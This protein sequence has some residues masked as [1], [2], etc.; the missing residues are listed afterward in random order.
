VILQT[1]WEKNK[2]DLNTMF[3]DVYWGEELTK[4]IRTANF[5]RSNRATFLTS[6]MGLSFLLLMPRTEDDVMVMGS[7]WQRRLRAGK[8]VTTADY[9]AAEK[10]PRMP[11]LRWDEVCMLFTTWALLL[12]MLFGPRC[13]HLVGLNSIRQ[14]VMSLSSTKHMYDATYF[15]NM[16]WC[17]LDDAVR[18]L[19][20]VVPYDDLVSA[21]EVECLQFPTT[22]LHRVADML[23]MQ[24]N[25]TMATFPREWRVYAEKR[26]TFG[27]FPATVSFGSS[28]TPTGS[29]T[30]GVSTITNSNKTPNSTLG[31]EEK[32]KEAP[33]DNNKQHRERHPERY[34]RNA[35]N[36]DVQQ[37]IREMLT[38]M[39]DTTFT[40]IL[41]ANNKYFGQ[42]KG[43]STFSQGICPAFSTGRCSFEKCR[44]A[45]L[46]GQET[47]QQWGKWLAKQLEPGCTRIK[48][49]ED[50]QPRKKFRGTRGDK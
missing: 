16:V 44:S 35:V 7:E 43:K 26:A 45:H 1:N 8:N 20:Q 25:Y 13:A 23:S 47:P 14:H 17:V 6:E 39:G 2:R 22:R 3:Y 31:S 12:K 10:A 38:G 5:T 48:S 27:Q 30:S 29:L 40:K 36:Q 50:I 4:T 33:G 21:N 19:N 41:D 28:S 11:P 37:D 18:W 46:V 9:K 15:A 32:G 42:L 49:G 34:S 24:S